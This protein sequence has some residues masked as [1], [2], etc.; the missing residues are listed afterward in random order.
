M[1]TFT[2]PVALTS[3]HFQTEPLPGKQ[4]A[5]RGRPGG[6]FLNL[7]TDPF[8]VWDGGHGLSAAPAALDTI[9]PPGVEIPAFP[10]RQP[11]F[12]V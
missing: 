1:Q 11:L 10:C 2:A 8:L 3:W 9:T 12:R 6:D 4:L 7:A 5:L